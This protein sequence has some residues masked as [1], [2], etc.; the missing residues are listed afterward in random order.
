MKTLIALLLA[1]AMLAVG[2]NLQRNSKNTPTVPSPAPQMKK[3]GEDAGVAAKALV[4]NSDQGTAR[5]EDARQGVQEVS[6]GG[7]AVAGYLSTQEA[8][9]AQQIR[10]GM[11]TLDNR[12]LPDL[13]AT[14]EYFAG[15]AA[16]AQQI[17]TDLIPALEQ[18]EGQA[19]VMDEQN[20]ALIKNDAETRARLAP[21]APKKSDVSTPELAAAVAAHDEA[22]TKALDDSDRAI[23]QY[24]MWG[25]LVLAC[26]GIGV[27]FLKQFQLGAG[28]VVF[29]VGV[30]GLCSLASAYIWVVRVG[31]LAL[32][33]GAVIWA[34]YQVRCETA[35]KKAVADQG[36]IER[37][38][39]V[40]GITA[41]L[42]SLEA[43]AADKMKAALQAVQAAVP[44]LEEKVRADLGKPPVTTSS[45]DGA[46]S[47]TQGTAE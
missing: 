8:A 43:A 47:A 37:K 32:F 30:F 23:L 7:K 31:S 2:C 44:G 35:T 42:Q 16:T 4:T 27:L 45:P 3:A 17:R 36:D 1:A 6:A 33:L 18:A 39:L 41:G 12:I 22:A 13:V 9:M 46:P 14:Q 26:M 34:I 20:R 5:I 21:R 38:N 11:A 28:L 19:K 24:F 40:A 15:I 29:G 10:A 25:G